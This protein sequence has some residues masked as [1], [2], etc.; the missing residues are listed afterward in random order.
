MDDSNLTDVQRLDKKVDELKTLI[1]H[2]AWREANLRD[3]IRNLE[4]LLMVNYFH[5]MTVENKRGELLKIFK[6]SLTEKYRL[7]A[8]STDVFPYL[9]AEL[10]KMP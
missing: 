6:E 1:E 3:R 8:K 4:S 10:E 5:S 7:M 9:K 2:A